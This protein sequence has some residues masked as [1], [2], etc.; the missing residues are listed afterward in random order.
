MSKRTA[1]TTRPLNAIALRGA[2]PAAERAAYVYVGNG[3]FMPANAAAWREVDD[4][5][6]YAAMI[7]ARSAAR[8]A[9]Q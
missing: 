4:W 7:T 5:N 9:V 6:A 2:V 3:T 1:T 8:S